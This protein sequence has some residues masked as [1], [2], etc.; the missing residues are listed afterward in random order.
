VDKMMLKKYAELVIHTGVNVQRNQPVVITAPIETAYFVRALA[1]AAYGAGAKDVHVNWLDDKL[2]RIRYLQ[3]PDEVFDEIPSWEKDF[4][5]TNLN[6]GAAFIEIDAADPEAF[7]GVDVNRIARQEKVGA[8]EFDEFNESLMANKN[9]WTIVSVPTAAWAKK[10]FPKHSEE[11]AMDK[12]WKAIIKS[13]RLDAED[14]VAAWKEHT[15]NLKKR[16]DFLNRK[17]FKYLRYSNSLG[18]DL[19]IELPEGHQWIGGA[20]YTIGGIEFNANMPTEEVYTL[21]K[22]NGVEGKV[23][24]TMPLNYNGNIIDNF[25][26]TFKEGRIVDYTAEKGLDMLR[27]LI[28]TDEGSHYLGEVALVPY[29]SP[30]SNQRILFYNTLFDENASCHLAIGKAYSTC[31]RNGRDMTE[32]ELLKAGVNDSLVHVDFMIGTEDLEITGI[33]AYGKEVPVFLKGNFAY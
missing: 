31:L 8:Q 10:I 23:V 19:I 6:N 3:A 30:I 20:E 11:E 32:E 9:A 12:L 24:S 27:T 14:P 28:E 2:S 29:D 26:L 1:E 4:T 21:P 18:T 7:K 17:N 15:A 5:M 13:I 25:T 33:T 16:V 22:R